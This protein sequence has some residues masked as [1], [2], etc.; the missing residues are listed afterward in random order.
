MSYFNILFT[1]ICA[2]AFW[3]AVISVS[4]CGLYVSHGG[5]EY[6]FMGPGSSAV[7]HR[8]SPLAQDTTLR[9]GYDYSK[10]RKP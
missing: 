10:L 5:G 8:C 2:V 4:G 6:T 3:A 1:M 7:A 9:W